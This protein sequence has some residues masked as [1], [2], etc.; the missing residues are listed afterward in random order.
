M[1]SSKLVNLSLLLILKV[2]RWILPHHISSNTG[3]PHV[4]ASCLSDLFILLLELNWLSHLLEL[5]VLVLGLCWHWSLSA[6]SPEDKLISIRIHHPLTVFLSSYVCKDRILL[7]L[8][9]S[10]LLGRHLWVYVI[11][12]LRHLLRNLRV[13]ILSL[14]LSGLRM[15]RWIITIWYTNISFLR[16]NL[17]LLCSSFFLLQSLTKYSSEVFE[18][19]IYFFFLT[20]HL[21]LSYLWI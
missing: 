6:Y 7:R 15:L 20:R 14:S 3:I 10:Y 16:V 19:F 4:V 11:W 2:L 5:L 1:V 8:L 17:V 9:L 18:C 13:R 21:S 12:L